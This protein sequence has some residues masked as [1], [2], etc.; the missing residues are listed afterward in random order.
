MINHVTVDF[1]ILCKKLP[2]REF[3]RRLSRVP[4]RF[5]PGAGASWEKFPGSIAKIH[6]EIILDGSFP[7]SSNSGF[8][9]SPT[10]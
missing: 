5:L 10:H 8:F 1:P 2:S 4:K 9:P 7:E 6:I 3:V